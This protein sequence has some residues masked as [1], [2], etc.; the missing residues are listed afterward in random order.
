MTKGVSSSI[1]YEADTPAMSRDPLSLAASQ[2][3]SMRNDRNQSPPF[4]VAIDLNLTSG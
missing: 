2:R 3:L 1:V 4:D